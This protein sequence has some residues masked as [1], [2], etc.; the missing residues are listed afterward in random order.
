M[1]PGLARAA[2]RR[3]RAP[4]KKPPVAAA[5]VDPVARVLVDLPLA[6]LDRPFDYLVPETMAADAVPG[7]R[8]KVRFA[9]QDVDAYVVARAAASDHDGRLSPLRRVVSAEPVLAPEIAALS[10][11]V[12]RRYAGAR[13]D[14]L[15]LAVP[16]RH[17]TAE[18]KESVPAPAA[19]LDAGGGREALGRPRPRGRLRGGT[20]RRG[21][22]ARGLV[23]GPGCRLADAARPGGRGDVRLGPRGAALR[24]RR[25]GRRPGG[26]RA[27]RRAR[28]RATTWRC[29]RTAARRRATATSWPSPAAPGAIVVGTRAA[30]FAPVHDLGL[31]AVWDDGDDLHAE[32]R[33][34]Y[35]H[36]REVLLTR[37]ERQGTAALVGG[38]ARTV[39]AEYLLTTGW[40]REIAPSRESL[41]ERVT[42]GVSG[43]SDRDLAR[44]PRARSERL[45]KQAW[46]TIRTAPDARVRCSCRPRAAAT[47][48]AWPASAAARP[49]AA[50][51]CSGPLRLSGP[52]APPTCGWCGREDP[53]WACPEC[54]HRGLRAPVR[55]EARTAEE[56]GRAFPGTVV[57]HSGGE[58]VLAAVDAEAAIVV[59]TPGAEPVA[60]GGYAAVVL[61]DTWL[62]LA[63]LD[64]RTQEEALRRWFNAAA[65]VAPGGRV[66]A[67]GDPAEP[68][69]Q[70]LVRWD[71]S[72]FARREMEERRSAH[73][74][75]ASRLATITGSPG[76]VDDALTLLSRPDAAELL[77][78]APVEGAEA[79]RGEVRAVVRV[80][81]A[82]GTA[83]SDALGELQRVRSARKLD[84]VRVRV[85]PVVL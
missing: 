58:R 24:P 36:T 55:G 81:R 62:A 16:P 51:T 18:K 54:G 42:V 41:R 74:P 14:V 17:A 10:A 64:L 7:A 52:T 71:P 40:A 49:P 11:D 22:S 68:A 21:L 67:V 77:G 39:E 34:P 44:D 23:G 15:R 79:D 9:G 38:F 43:A 72:G 85:D 48:R 70:A 76:A 5:E 56:L 28:A 59:A 47:P 80:P 69:I 73:L 37:A 83:L 57:R 20:R 2:A 45:P 6:H 65:L 32:P 31:V 53:A 13:A 61:L 12:A 33:A 78:P 60:E 1:L 75:P 8:V 30:A 50:P 19:D 84:P 26:R 27:A 3:G 82:Q 46:D 66:L 63:R 35:P 29:G 4:A 25:Q